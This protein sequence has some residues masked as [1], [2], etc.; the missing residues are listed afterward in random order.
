M[1]F[2]AIKLLSFSMSYFVDCEEWFGILL[3]SLPG[4]RREIVCTLLS[5]KKSL[6]VD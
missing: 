1:F 4:A 5:L 3:G 2:V 6:I